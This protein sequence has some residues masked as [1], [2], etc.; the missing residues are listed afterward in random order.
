MVSPASVAKS[1]TQAQGQG[2]LRSAF[3]TFYKHF[4]VPF[5]S[6]DYILK[7]T[8]E[9]TESA[10]RQST[11]TSV[12]GSGT[13]RLDVDLGCA[14]QLNPRYCDSLLFVSGSGSILALTKP[15]T[16]HGKS[17][18]RSFEYEF[19][20]EKL[21]IEYLTHIRNSQQHGGSLLSRITDVLCSR[22][23]SIGA[24]LK[25]TPRHYMVMVDFIGNNKT[26]GGGRKWDLKPPEFFEVRNP[27]TPAVVLSQPINSVPILL[28][29][30]SGFD[31]GFPN[32][33]V[34]S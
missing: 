9:C 23:A 7:V 34:Y 4:F 27:P 32:N 17:I 3:W 20:Y 5:W 21:L 33:K 16:N 12:E 19:M 1:S 26:K 31:T 22:E 30:S 11:S 10:L 6:R 28:T 24:L 13:E 15:P 14:L 2:S 29:T 18:S 8:G 25:M